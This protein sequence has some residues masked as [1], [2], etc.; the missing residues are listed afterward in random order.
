M[1]HIGEMRII[2]PR[3]RLHELATG[4][5]VSLA[6]LARMLD[7]PDHYFQRFVRMGIPAALENEDRRFL[8]LF[9]GVSQMEL[10]GDRPPRTHA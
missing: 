6:A 1:R 5:R 9:F 4:R 8:A 2:D 3:S 7:K 10:G